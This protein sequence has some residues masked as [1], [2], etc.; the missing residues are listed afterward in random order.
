MENVKFILASKSITRKKLLE[1]AGLVF[2]SFPAQIDEEEIKKSLVAA[3]VH[4][5]E[6]A[7]FLAEQKACKVSEKYPESIVIGGDQVL[8]FNG[9]IFSKPRTENQAKEQILTLRNSLHCL[10][11]SVCVAEGGQ[12][13]WHQTDKALM[14]FRDFSDQF[15]EQ[16]LVKSKKE[17]FNGP[18]GYKVEGHGIQLLDRI[19]G[20][21][22]TV[23]GLP[24]IPLLQYLRTRGLMTL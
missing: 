11:S 20:D 14:R 12:R 21:F 1:N 16:Y 18:G 5:Q 23:L 4:P 17:L 6:I 22:F 8:E 9:S 3:R 2:D 15:L 13:V 7:A 10:I 24:I 19:E